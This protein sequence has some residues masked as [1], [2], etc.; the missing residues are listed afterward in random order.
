MM[1]GGEMLG[2][3]LLA[4]FVSI[5]AVGL[6][7]MFDVLADKMPWKT[8]ALRAAI[9]AASIPM[10]AITTIVAV[11]N[12]FDSE[13]LVIATVLIALGAFLT[14]I[15][16][17]PTSYWFLKRRQLRRTQGSENPSDDL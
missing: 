3:V 16:A 15:I 6:A 13:I 17:F 4:L 9:L 7:F 12:G 5:F 10:F 11:E 14:A 2:L 1:P 8:K